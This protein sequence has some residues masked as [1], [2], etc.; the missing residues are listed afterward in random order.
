M[1]FCYWLTIFMS[2]QSLVIHL[3]EGLWPV[4]EVHTALLITEWKNGF[5]ME[6]TDTF[7]VTVISSTYKVE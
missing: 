4:S 1:L 5:L 6:L 7:L 3:F 2:C